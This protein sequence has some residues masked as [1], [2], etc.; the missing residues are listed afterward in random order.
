MPNPLKLYRWFR[1]W[2][3]DRGSSRT[4]LQRKIGNTIVSKITRGEFETVRFAEE[5]WDNLVI[6]DACRHDMMEEKNPFDAEVQ[7]R[8]SNASQTIEFLKKNFSGEHLDTVYVT[9]NP[10]VAR[11][12]GNFARVEHVWK[13]RWSDEHDTVLPGDVTDAALELAEE[14][15]D[16]K[17]I[18]HYMQPHFPFIDSEIEQGSYKGERGGRELPSVWERMYAG[19][20]DKEEV[21]IDY[22]HNLEVA[23]PEVKRLVAELRGKTV[24]TS[25]HGNLFGKK[26]S[27][28]PFK[29]Y[30][31]PGGIKDEELCRI[32]WIELPF[33]SRKNI[34]RAEK[35]SEEEFDS[36]EVKDKLADLGYS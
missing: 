3:P 36:E 17:L 16:K 4:V 18:V 11:F 28:L 1:N 10:Q 33:E 13:D 21:R 26:V 32:P 12:G 8:Y 9:A 6:L 23:L 7:E 14:Y 30:G 19:E 2:L 24:V 31:H 35:K 25:D 22:E 27:F 20:L 29:V 34:S 5:D 15:P